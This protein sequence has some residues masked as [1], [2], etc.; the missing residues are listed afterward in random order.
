MVSSF[1]PSAWHV[2]HS[3]LVCDMRIRHDTQSPSQT[4]AQARLF[5]MIFLP[6]HKVGVSGCSCSVLPTLPKWRD[7]VQDH[8]IRFAHDRAPVRRFDDAPRGGTDPDDTFGPFRN[9]RRWDLRSVKS[10]RCVRA[11]RRDVRRCRILV[12]FCPRPRFASLEA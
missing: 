4:P 10:W 9:D 12:G 1:V 5:E 7:A 8:V 3:L 6:D 11:Q 2:S